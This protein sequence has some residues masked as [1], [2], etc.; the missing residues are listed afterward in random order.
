MNINKINKNFQ[1]FPK[2]RVAAV[3]HPACPFCSQLAVAQGDGFI[4][5][6]VG[7]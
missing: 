4:L 5:G 2:N 6:R 3:S 7:I 1:C